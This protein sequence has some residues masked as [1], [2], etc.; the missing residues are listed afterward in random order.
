VANRAREAAE[1]ARDLGDL[2]AML[3][4]GN[5]E[6][7]ALQ[8]LVSAGVTNE[9]LLDDLDMFKRL[10]GA[11]LALGRD[12]PKVRAAVAARLADRDENLLIKAWL[13]EFDEVAAD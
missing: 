12:H 9:R 13:D 10:T 4:A 5:A 8:V 1:D 3:R 11:F 6:T 7:R 2:D